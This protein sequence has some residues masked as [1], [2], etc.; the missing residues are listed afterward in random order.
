MEAIITN[1]GWVICSNCG[2]KLAK[3]EDQSEKKKETVKISFKCTSCKQI[4]KLE[5]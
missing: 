5:V 2:H 3:I 1:Q 4:N